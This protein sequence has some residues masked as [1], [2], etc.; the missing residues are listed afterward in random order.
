MKEVLLYIAEHLGFLWEH[1][2]ESNDYKITFSVSSP[3]SGCVVITSSRIRIQ[4][5]HHHGELTMEVEP[6]FIKRSDGYIPYGAIAI[7]VLQHVMTGER[8]APGTR[9]TGEH[10]AFLRDHLDDVVAH[11][12]PELWPILKAQAKAIGTR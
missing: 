4:L 1:N 8:P 2:V 12:S 11:M 5:V 3:G 9:V 7:E 10:A 6:A